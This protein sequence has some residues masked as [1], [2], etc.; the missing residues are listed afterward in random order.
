MASAREG[1]EGEGPDLGLAKRELPAWIC[2]SCVVK[3]ASVACGV[4][5]LGLGLGLGL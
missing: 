1:A 3:V 4:L 5:G 2:S